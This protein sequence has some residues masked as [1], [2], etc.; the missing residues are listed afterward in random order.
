[1]F[2]VRHMERLTNATYENMKGQFI[3]A[4]FVDACVRKV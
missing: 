1:M 3:Y 4:S 2:I